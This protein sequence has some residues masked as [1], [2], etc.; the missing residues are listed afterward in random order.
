MLSGKVRILSDLHLGHPGS[1]IG[2]VEDLRPLL[3]GMDTVVFNGDTCELAYAEWAERG[4]Q[5]LEAL[6]SL[7]NSP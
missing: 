3:E 2:D 4:E 6:R 7:T 1:L 5:W